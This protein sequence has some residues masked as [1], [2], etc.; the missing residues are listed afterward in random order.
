MPNR[1]PVNSSELSLMSVP[2]FWP[3]AMAVALLEQA[4]ELYASRGLDAVR[5]DTRFD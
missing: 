2:A 5:I 3:M 1:P 4:S